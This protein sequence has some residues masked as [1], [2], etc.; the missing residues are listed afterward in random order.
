M[1]PASKHDPDQ[2]PPIHLG[3]DPRKYPKRTAWGHSAVMRRP[4]GTSSA[5]VAA[6]QPAL[7]EHAITD[8]R[9]TCPQAT[10]TALGMPQAEKEMM[11]A[12]SPH[13]L[14][15]CKQGDQ[16][17]RCKPRKPVLQALNNAFLPTG[18]K[19]RSPNSQGRFIPG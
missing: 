11:S 5:H 4:L 8:L 16:I 12:G 9:Q 17:A 19:Q 7:P 2:Q 15:R 14:N 1:K 13:D 3:I 6:T 10:S 18:E